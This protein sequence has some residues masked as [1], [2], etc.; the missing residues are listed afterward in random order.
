MVKLWKRLA[1]LGSVILWKEMDCVCFLHPKDVSVV[2]PSWIIVG[3]VVA[4]GDGNNIFGAM[5]I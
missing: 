2:V 1:V 5:G 3:G 4:I